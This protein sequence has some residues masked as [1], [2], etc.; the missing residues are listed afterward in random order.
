MDAIERTERSN[1]KGDVMFAT[2]SNNKTTQ[3]VGFIGIVDARRVE[4]LLLDA[5]KS[6]TD[7]KPAEEIISQRL[8]L[9]GS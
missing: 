3:R 5:F 6:G 7:E 8:S 4:R 9:F 1:G 2:S